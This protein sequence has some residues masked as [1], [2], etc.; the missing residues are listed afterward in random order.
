VDW[1][2]DFLN[3]YLASRYRGEMIFSRLR[4]G[5]VPATAIP[6]TA[7]IWERKVWGNIRFWADAVVVTDQKLILIEAKIKP[8]PGVLGQI[9]I[10]RRLLPQT[11]ELKPF[12]PRDVEAQ[13]VYCI[14]FPLI[15]ALAREKG[16][17]AIQFPYSRLREWMEQKTPRE[18]MVPILGEEGA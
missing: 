9:E 6:P 5:T 16:I 11:P 17:R 2:A 12:F 7:D 4:L 14:E 18:K 10:Y 15:V 3:E 13:L 1:E 8:S